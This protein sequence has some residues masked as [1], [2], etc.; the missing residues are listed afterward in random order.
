VEGGLLEITE[1]L[2]KP[3]IDSNGITQ[4]PLQ[5]I[6]ESLGKN[7]ELNQKTSTAKTIYENILVTIGK[8]KIKAPEDVNK[9]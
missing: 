2:S 3:F 5:V 1:E 4:V 7:V 6:S 8:E 9:I